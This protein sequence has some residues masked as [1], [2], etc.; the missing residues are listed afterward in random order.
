MKKS[1]DV[2]KIAVME[3]EPELIQPDEVTVSKGIMLDQSTPYGEN[4]NHYKSILLDNST[5]YYVCC[6][7]INT[8][9]LSWTEC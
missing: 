5:P 1:D 3:E 6:I 9:L 8:K 4:F 2:G 7:V